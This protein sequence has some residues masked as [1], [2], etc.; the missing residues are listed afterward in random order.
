MDEYE[1]CKPSAVDLCL[2]TLAW[3]GTSPQTFHTASVSDVIR[4]GLRGQIGRELFSLKFL[5]AL[6]IVLCNRQRSGGL[7]SVKKT[8][9]CAV[10]L[11]LLVTGLPNAGNGQ[12]RP[13]SEDVADCA[14][15][16]PVPLPA[17][18]TCAGTIPRYAACEIEL[19]SARPEASSTSTRATRPSSPG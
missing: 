8:W 4:V 14:S 11:L 18:P 9:L 19:T 10:S 15:S 13:A 7:M 1:Y 17:L 2:L 3:L 12:S 5:S 6:T 16:V